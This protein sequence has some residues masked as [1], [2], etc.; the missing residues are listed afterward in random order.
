MKHLLSTFILSL[1]H[2]ARFYI[3]LQEHAW[4]DKSPYEIITNT[5][6]KGRTERGEGHSGYIYYQV[7]LLYCCLAFIQF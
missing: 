5:S 1:G 6:T 4:F 2:L 3:S 7:S